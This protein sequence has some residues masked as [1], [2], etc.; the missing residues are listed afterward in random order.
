MRHLRNMHQAMISN[1]SGHAG[2]LL[3]VGLALTDS[4]CF[5]ARPHQARLLSV[6]DAEMQL[7][8]VMDPIAHAVGQSALVTVHGKGMTWLHRPQYC[9]IGHGSRLR[10]RK[11]SSHV[12]LSV[13]SV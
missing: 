7:F 9:S 13:C 2:H 4:L 10:N 6:A 1:Q 12:Q 11:R 5:A 8:N 3:A